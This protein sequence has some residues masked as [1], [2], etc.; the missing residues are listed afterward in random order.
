MPARPLRIA[1]R[2]N[3]AGARKP[4]FRPRL[5]RAREDAPGPGRSTPTQ[6]RVLLVEDDFMVASE[7]EHAL[8]AA[9]FTVVGTATTAEEAIALATQEHPALVVM[10]I[11]LAGGRDGID[12]ALELFRTLGLRC[13]FATAHANSEVRKRA[14]PAAPLGWLQKPYTT[15]SLA[16]LVRR[17][18]KEL[19][20]L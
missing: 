11:R 8:A 19:G 13:V 18:V 7:A 16:E 6:P 12:A 14:A 20:A 10:D 5:V 4:D 15:D 1:F 3:I 9:G 17:A 2:E